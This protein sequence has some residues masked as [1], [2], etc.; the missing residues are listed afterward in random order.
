MYPI[1]ECN[2]EMNDDM[3]QAIDQLYGIKTS[4]DLG[5][6]FVKANQT[7]KFLNFYITISNYGLRDASDASL[8]IFADDQSVREFE[9]GSIKLGTKKFLNV[10]NMKIDESNTEIVKFVLNLKDDD[11][12]KD[13]D[14]AELYLKYE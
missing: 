9:L 10:Q 2:Q 11:L 6:E 4:P 13:N 7:G 1:T 3:I 8:E 14:F 12:Y 5:I